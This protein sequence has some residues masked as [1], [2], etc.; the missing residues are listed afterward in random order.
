MSDS[1]SLNDSNGSGKETTESH[2]P[3]CTKGLPSATEA[4]RRVVTSK[5]RLA[6]SIVPEDRARDQ[7][8]SSLL[9][10]YSVVVAMVEKKWN[11]EKNTLR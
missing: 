5:T 11:A 10:A 6:A 8:V 3:R 2:V 7:Q 4:S 9:S 1:N